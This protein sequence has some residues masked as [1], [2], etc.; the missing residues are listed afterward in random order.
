MTK[1]NP[2]RVK[3]HVHAL[4]CLYSRHRLRATADQLNAVAREQGHESNWLTGYSADA[5]VSCTYWA[6]E[7]CSFCGWA[8]NVG[9]YCNE[10]NA[11]VQSHRRGR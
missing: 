7:A 4:R 10:C 9:E 8:I 11:V 2:D 3:S 6:R 5:G 1:I